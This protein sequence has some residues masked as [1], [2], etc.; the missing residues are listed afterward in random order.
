[1]TGGSFCSPV[2]DDG[3]EF[4]VRRRAK[5]KKNSGES[6]E[7]A[8]LTTN[9]ISREGN[10]ATVAPQRGDKR[11]IEREGKNNERSMSLE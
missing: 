4:V 9:R 10:A 5:K 11:T 2:T 6:C 3:E 7:F 1:M 8:R